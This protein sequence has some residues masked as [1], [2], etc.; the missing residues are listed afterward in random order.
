VVVGDEDTGA[1]A[2]SLFL[3]RVCPAARLTVLPTTGHLVNLEEPEI[4]NR[5][6]ERFL[7]EVDAR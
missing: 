1:L 2:T 7:A 6:T 3:H 4:F 5:L